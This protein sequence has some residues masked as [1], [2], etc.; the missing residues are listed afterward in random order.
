M[1]LS[2]LINASRRPHNRKLHGAV[3]RHHKPCLETDVR[4]EGLDQQHLGLRL[5]HRPSGREGVARAARGSGNDYSVRAIR[6]QLHAV[7]RHLDVEQS[8]ESAPHDGL[9][10]RVVDD[11]GL[12]VRLG[13]DLRLKHEPFFRANDHP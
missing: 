9:V 4:R 2:T 3:V 1:R 5:E 10:Q 7:Y 12:P 8:R 13:R 6:R 11:S